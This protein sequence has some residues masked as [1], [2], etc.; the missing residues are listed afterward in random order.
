MAREMDVAPVKTQPDPLDPWAHRSD[1]MQCMTCIFFVEKATA[2]NLNSP[3]GR[4]RRHAPTMNG[5]PIVFP[6]DWCGD[7]RLD[8]A[9]V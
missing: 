9:K 4:C 6:T 2:P 7:H 3:L 8:E 1:N 5:Y